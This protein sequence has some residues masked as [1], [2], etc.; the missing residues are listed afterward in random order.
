MPRPS[1]SRARVRRVATA[2]FLLFLFSSGPAANAANRDYIIRQFQTDVGLP[3]NTVT[4]L[5]QTPDGYIW[6]A[7]FS[8]LARFDGVRFEVFDPSNTPE[9][10][11]DRITRLNATRNGS[12]VMMTET[13]DVVIRENGQFKRRETKNPAHLGFAEDMEG[14]IWTLDPYQSEPLWR[15]LSGDEPRTRSGALDALY[16]SRAYGLWVGPGGSVFYPAFYQDQ[17]PQLKYWT[18]TNGW[19]HFPLFPSGAQERIERIIAQ[20]EGTWLRTDKAM[21]MFDGK[22]LRHRL[23][24][25]TN[26][27]T[28]DVLADHR[29]NLWVAYHN[30]QLFRFGL[31]DGSHDE[32]LG[33]PGGGKAGI[34]TLLA[35]HEGNLWVG[36]SD[37]GLV[38]IRPKIMRT[39]GVKD[40]LLHPTIRSVAADLDGNLWI[41]AVNGLNLLRN[42]RI[43]RLPHQFDGDLAWNTTIAGPGEMWVGTYGEGLFRCTPQTRRQFTAKTPITFVGPAFTCLLTDSQ[44]FVWFGNSEG[45]FRFNSVQPEPAP[46]PINRPVDVRAVAQGKDGA[47]YAGSNGAGFFARDTAT[48][49]WKQFSRA[50]GLESE[51]VYAL[52]VDPHSAV[53][54]GMSGGGLARY[55]DGKITSLKSLLNSLPRTVTCIQSD[56]LGYL[57]LGS[58]NGV[59]RVKI[60]E[61]NA[62]ADRQSDT[63]TVFQYGV[64][65]GMPT[66]TC[67]QG[68]Q[69]AVAKTRDGRI[70]FATTEGLVSFDPHQIPFNSQ[71]P[72]LVIETVASRDSRIDLTSAPKHP[73]PKAELTRSTTA[74]VQTIFSAPGTDPLEFEFTGLSFSPPENVQF[75][76]K[77]DG[78]DQKWTHTKNRK[79]VYQ[80]LP[81]G[82]YTFRVRASNSDGVWNQQGASLAIIQLPYY[83][84][85]AWFKFALTAAMVLI[86]Y[87]AYKYRLAQLQRVGQ[88]RARIAADLHDEVGSNMGAVILNS[89]LLKA[90]A[91][92]SPPEREQIAD[93]HRVAQ[94]TAQAIREI[95][96]FINPD[97]D[98]LDEMIVRMNEVAARLSK[99]HTVEFSAPPDPPKTALSL[100]FRR[101][102]MAIYKESLNNVA[103]HARASHITVA[104]SITSKELQIQ[105][106]DNGCGFPLGEERN[107][108]G[109]RN[110]RHRAD[111]LNAK[112][113]VQS[114]PG[115][116]TTIKFNVPLN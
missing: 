21:Y 111:Q 113:N 41:C 106:R 45:L 13:G 33:L 101:N 70:W 7:T 39:F 81:P 91:S 50:D 54:L 43:E 83:W 17:P 75:Q 12:L 57:W 66:P 69:P 49:P 71:P 30:G 61:L 116:G 37:F 20:S 62:V 36:L 94:N 115:S 68:I 82:S 35:D 99:N 29:G 90:S 109:L 15:L 18:A 32:I 56:D 105:V 104:I 28:A 48:S 63:A 27:W 10:P 80:R 23:P 85:T 100:E 87:A 24:I 76:Y 107:G 64:S 47:M 55:V 103:R 77:M 98:Y 110:L 92:L 26:S 59:Y 88:L 58:V 34:R 42:D 19:A 96:W 52:H 40:G 51:Q 9:L 31:N 93:I 22:T 84:E 2:I 72:T 102:V 60:S 78:L 16:L 5:A 86:V 44:G 79:A 6:C 97:F 38:Q 14:N 53:W 89:D 46:L 1:N 67:T 65:S 4:A 95:S 25:L 112:F 8:G 11:T 74:K 108:H 73:S 3:E 114:A